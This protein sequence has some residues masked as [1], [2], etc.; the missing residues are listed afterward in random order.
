MKRAY[1][2]ERRLWIVAIL[3]SLSITA[4][5]GFCQI[6]PSGSKN[7]LVQFD[8]ISELN[9]DRDAS[10]ASTVVFA[11]Y[12]VCQD[13]YA[14]SIVWSEPHSVD[15]QD[16]K[17]TVILSDRAAFRMNDELFPNSVRYNATY[18][19]PV[20]DRGSFRWGGGPYGGDEMRFAEADAASR[21]VYVSDIESMKG[22]PADANGVIDLE[23][24]DSPDGAK[25]KLAQLRVR[26]KGDLVESME[27]FDKQQRSLARMRYEYDRS[28]GAPRISTLVTELPV[29]PEKLAMDA[30][31][32]VVPKNGGAAE[33][34]TYKVADVNYV[35]HKGGR[36]CTVTYKDV[37]MNG[38]VLRLPV[39]VEVRRS[40]DKRLVRSAKLMN[41]KRVD[42]DKAAVWEA[43]KAFAGLGNDYWKFERL[44]AK[45]I[46][47]RP[48]LGP[49]R[50]DPNDLA[51]ARKLVAKYPVPKVVQPAGGSE[52]GTRPQVTRPK[53]ME[54][55][56]NDVRAMRQLRA[57]YD[58]RLSTIRGR[59]PE[60]EQEISRLNSDVRIILAYHHVPVLPEDKPPEPNALDSKLI[61]QLA[62]HYE[63]LAVQQ[64]GELTGRLKA[65]HVLTRLDLIVKDYDAFERHTNRYL[66]DLHDA[67]LGGVYMT[68]G[69]G[70][71]DDLAEAGQYAKA[72]K[73][74]RQW[75]D[76]S[77][78]GND[79]DGVYRFCG[80]D[81]GG[82]GD[83]WLS[84]Q[85]LDRF[86]TRPGLSPTERYEGLALRAIALDRIDKLLA[87]PETA[88]DESRK[89]QAQWVLSTTTKAEIAKR[90]EPAV[91]QAVSAWQSLG[92]SRLTDAKPY[93]TPLGA[94]SMRNM[95]GFP[96]ATRLQETSAQL[97]QIVEQRLGQRGAASRSSGAA[98]RSGQ[99]ARS[100]AR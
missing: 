52:F 42:L 2:H 41:F 91:R 93:S 56:P 58:K 19:K 66:Q 35:S 32:I 8:V 87:D 98:P 70:N 25:R 20:G 30:N 80:S 26:S 6:Q 49:L 83:P 88:Y 18:P 15:V 48:K 72:N 59:V 74:M 44:N 14:V 51:F 71:V 75:A 53:Q 9:T 77:A 33:K 96:E 16:R 38:K 23:K 34:K 64:K 4:G 40:D 69:C 73:V 10:Y 100:G 92:P 84:I 90:V 11:R 65:L 45:Y 50:V 39:Q 29:R 43:A 21:R 12:W 17:T 95:F 61:R 36:T 47:F 60:S 85:L 28:A 24:T 1:T 55:E 99:P 89:T 3:V 62:E 82:K 78:A 7:G 67:G 97:N 94:D 5:I 76:I 68:G 79:A 63:P 86:L 57:F 31:A 22:T 27:L 54:V 37:T 46:A 13:Y 81:K